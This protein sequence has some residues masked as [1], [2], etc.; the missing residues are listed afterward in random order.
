MPRIKACVLFL[1]LAFAASPSLAGGHSSKVVLSEVR[2]NSYGIVLKA[3]TPHGDPDNCGRNTEIFIPNSQVADEKLV[4]L[5]VTAL[6]SKSRIRVYL[7]G[8]SGTPPDA[9][10]ISR[11]PMFD[12]TIYGD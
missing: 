5:F 4:S 1:L 8:C 11:D 9:F 7:D 6:A 2:Y 10:A 12:V 3:S